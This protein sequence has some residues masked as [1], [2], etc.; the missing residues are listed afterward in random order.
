MS[1]ISSGLRA[2]GAFW[3]DFVVGDDWR[4]ALAVVLALAATA[5]LSQ[6]GVPSWWVVPIVA[7][8]VLTISLV[9]AVR[10]ADGAQTE[11]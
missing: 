10:R 9:R 1:R 4:M 3:W 11:S 5:G 2:F 6:L 7:L 8:G